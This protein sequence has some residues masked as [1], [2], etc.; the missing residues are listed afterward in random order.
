M[1]LW[2]LCSKKTSY[3]K[4]NK[5]NFY[6]NDILKQYF[7][8]RCTPNTNSWLIRKKFLIDNS[9]YFDR[10]LNWGEDMLFFSKILTIDKSVTCVPEYLTYNNKDVKNSLST[11]NINKLTKDLLWIEKYKKFLTSISNDEKRNQEVLDAI[12]GYFLPAVLVYRL[13]Q[14]KNHISIENYKKALN[15]TSYYIDKIKMINGLRSI[16]LLIIKKLL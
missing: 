9:I 16:K 6:K 4:K 2:K 3:L 7:L 14:N 1:L 15:N 8:N 10:E 5:I 11:N 12:N 13:Y